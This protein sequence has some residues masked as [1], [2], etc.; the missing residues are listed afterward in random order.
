MNARILSIRSIYASFMAQ[1]TRAGSS[2]HTRLN[3]F[4]FWK[5]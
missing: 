3:N 5:P 2:L 1:A 4:G